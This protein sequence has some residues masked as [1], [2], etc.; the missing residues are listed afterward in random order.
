M[1]QPGGLHDR[2]LS[3][4]LNSPPSAAVH[5]RPRVRVRAGHGRW[6]TLV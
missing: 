3:F 5:R 4:G 2:G 6:W 1:R